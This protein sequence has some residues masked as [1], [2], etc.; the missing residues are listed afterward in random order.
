M[1]GSNILKAYETTVL[2]LTRRSSRCVI[3]E[4]RYESRREI[5]CYLS[6]SVELLSVSPLNDELS[7]VVD[8]E[9]SSRYASASSFMP[10]SDARATL[11]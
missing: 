6:A 4:S 2:L 9:K 10:D 5:N 11:T 3:I 8:L 1:L 7:G